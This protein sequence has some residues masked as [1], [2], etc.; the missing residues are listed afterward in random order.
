MSNVSVIIIINLLIIH[1]SLLNLIIEGID[2]IEAE[3]AYVESP[4][5]DCIDNIESLV[6][7]SSICTTYNSQLS[8]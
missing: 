4:V 8:P 2:P 6:T 3:V 5:D 1:Y 7:P